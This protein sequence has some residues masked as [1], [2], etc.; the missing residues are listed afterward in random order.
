MTHNLRSL[1]FVP[2]DDKS[3][4]ERAA[5]SGADAL[6]LDWEDAVLP[7]RKHLARDFCQDLKLLRSSS[8]RLFIRINSYRTQWHQDDLKAAAAIRPDGIALPKCE[9]AEEIHASTAILQ[10]QSSDW[11]YNLCPIIESPRGLLRA[12]A[13]ATA[14]PL[15]SALAFGAQ[16]FCSSAGIHPAAEEIE[17]LMAKSA[18]VTTARAYQL[19]AIDSPVVGLNDLQ[20]VRDA[21]QRSYRMGFTGKL[22]IHPKHVP[23]INDAFAPSAEE[24]SYAEEILQQA[25]IQKAGAFAWKGQMIDEAILEKARHTLQKFETYSKQKT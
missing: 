18:I 6:I 22:A 24:A 19:A 5:A 16:D 10:E 25:A 14:S 21:A 13:I 3:K 17:L 1:L 7:T 2:G 11:R 9:S 8:K 20:A 12:E 4:I 23:M 15:I